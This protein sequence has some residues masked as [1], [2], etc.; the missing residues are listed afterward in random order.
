MS[1][2]VVVDRL[3]GPEV[4]SWQRWPVGAPEG[5]Q[6]HIRQHAIGLNFVDVY[7]RT[8]LYPVQPPFV[9][10]N[11]GAGE[12]LAVGADVTTFKPGDRVAY[13]GVPGAYAEE[14]LMPADKAVLLPDGI[15]Y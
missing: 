3:G 9:G 1:N 6:I 2:A 5:G 15:S 4:L 14:R 7:Q 12:V 13:Q 10:G 8:G 11:E